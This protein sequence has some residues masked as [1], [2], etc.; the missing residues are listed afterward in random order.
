MQ[1]F[2]PIQQYNFCDTFE[3]TSPTYVVPEDLIQMGCILGK[4]G[5]ID[6]KYECVIRLGRD[7]ILYAPTTA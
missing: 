1:Y 4:H 5:E 2:H 3:N 6:E 7:P